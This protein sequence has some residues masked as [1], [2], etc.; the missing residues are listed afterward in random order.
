MPSS[1]R[2]RR[3]PYGEGHVPLDPDRLAGLARSEAGPGGEPYTVRQVRG[4]DKAYRCPGCDQLVPPGVAHVVA[5]PAEHLLGAQAGLADRRHWHT[6]CWQAR[7]RRRP[8]R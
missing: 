2:S 3:R 7:D 8:T 1:R 6:A 4:S 5:W